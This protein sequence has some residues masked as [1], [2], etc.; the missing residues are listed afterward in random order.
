MTIEFNTL[1]PL[2]V[3]AENRVRIRLAPKA[4]QVLALFLAHANQ[5]VGIEEIVEE[6][7]GYDPPNS[8][9]TTAQTYI[10]HLRKTLNHHFT[11]MDRP[12]LLVTTVGPGYG[13]HMN[14]ARSDVDAF[15]RLSVR[16][17]ALIENGDPS[18]AAAHLNEAL[19]IWRGSPLVNVHLGKFLRAHATKLKEEHI[20]TLELRIEADLQLGRH[21]G[22]IGELRSLVQIH[23]KN[24]W[25]HARLIE[26]LSYCGRRWEALEAYQN[27]YAALYRELGM[28]PSQ[29]V[30]ELQRAILGDGM[31]NSQ[32]PGRLLANNRR[33]GQAGTTSGI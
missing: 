16:G 12:P 27:L 2:E 6:L 11:T 5:V 31:I 18:Q 19:Q 15:R 24:E 7:W 21:R 30:Q 33:P 3:V 14:G 28:V 22:L 1:G 23:P 13:L 20:D 4:R 25:L 32:R 8:A 9:I 29:E 26:T 10:C 17:R